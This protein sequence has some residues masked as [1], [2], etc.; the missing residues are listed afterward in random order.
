MG[1]AITEA[2]ADAFRDSAVAGLDS[3]GVHKPFKAQIRAL[4]SLIDGSLA[5]VLNGLLIGNAVLYATR[6]PGAGTL[7]NDLAHGAGSLGVVYNDS[8]AAYNGVYVKAGASGAGSWALTN[9][10]LPGT[11]AA[12]LAALISLCARIKPANMGF[13]QPIV[14]DNGNI[15]GGGVRAVYVPRTFYSNRNGES[16]NATLTPEAS[17]LA[18]YVK[19]TTHATTAWTVYLDLSKLRAANT[20]ATGAVIATSAPPTSLGSDYVPLASG[21]G[22]AFWSPFKMATTHD[23]GVQRIAFDGPVIIQDV[24]D[25]TSRKVLVPACWAMRTN[26]YGQS[27]RVAPIDGSR[28]FE[29]PLDTAGAAPWTMV[30]DWAKARANSPTPIADAVYARDYTTSPNVAGGWDWSVLGYSFAGKVNLTHGLLASGS[31]A[32][33]TCRISK[34]PALTQIQYADTAYVA[35]DNTALTALGFSLGY[36]SATGAAFVGEN[37]RAPQVGY[38]FARVYV[39]TD[40]P[41]DFGAPSIVVSDRVGGFGGFR[42]FAMTLEKKLSSSA[43]IYSVAAPL[44]LNADGASYVIGSNYTAGKDIRLTGAQVAFSPS[45]IA[46]IDRNDYPPATVREVVLDDVARRNAPAPRDWLLPP[47]LWVSPGKPLPLFARNATAQRDDGEGYLMAISARTAG[48]GS[49]P[50]FAQGSGMVD[51]AP[52]SGGTGRIVVRDRRSARERLAATVNLHLAPASPA[53]TPSIL[54]IG[55]SITDRGLPTLVHQNLAAR[56]ITATMIG[57]VLCETSPDGGT[58]RL[59]EARGGKK[60][61]EHVNIATTLPYVAAGDEAT[62]L[63]MSKAAK[64]AVNPFLRLSTGGDPAGAVKNGKIFDLA[65]YLSRFSL[66]TPTHVVIGLGDN[67][68][69]FSG[70]ADQTAAISESMSI[71]VSQ[72]RAAL[73]TA[74]I[75]LVANRVGFTDLANNL[76]FWPLMFAQNIKPHVTYARATADANVKLIPVWMHQS[77]DD[78]WDFAFADIDAATG[79]QSMTLAEPVHPQGANRQRAAEAIAS[80]VCATL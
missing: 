7:F 16:F 10:P 54:M 29:L 57:T 3:S 40:T 59:C 35:I 66:A 1:N 69:I 70:G 63:A 25:M 23:V 61:A 18:G 56:G 76:D 43:A 51:L 28:Y 26:I 50:F 74:K 38:L 80:W 73:P 78:G 34:T 5:T 12:D 33:N 45:P 75:S 27:M 37:I 48:G 4:F 32:P 42:G 53:G 2:G 11:Y 52:T 9:L 39:Q 77:I 67:D 6:G 60:Y 41:N 55:D 36:K 64:Q 14:I 24:P 15:Y 19:V 72:T 71:M 62:Y 46:W 30:L 20:A 79:L 17:E 49:H 58:A 21:Y 44:N 22:N 8:T 47:D 65:F 31:Y 13:D 68:V